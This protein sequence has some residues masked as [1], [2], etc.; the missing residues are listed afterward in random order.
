[1]YIA[2][3]KKKQGNKTYKS[4]L[5]RESYRDN[6][7]VKHRTIA[8]ISKL[9]AEH[10]S[11]LKASFKGEKSNINISDLGIGRSYEYGGSFALREVAKDIGL[12]KAIF[13]QRT[14]WRENILAMII[15]RILYQGSK[16]NLVNTYMD[17]ALWEIAGHKFGVRPNIKNDCYKPMDELLS[18]KD[19]IERK[20]AKRHLNNGSI[21]LYDITNTWLEGEYSDSDIVKYGRGKGGKRG[22]KQISIGLL[23]NSNGCPV[24]IEIFKGNTSD[25]TTVL[26]QIRKI[27][28]KYGI[29]EAVFVGD[30]GMLTQKRIN[31]IDS[32]YFKTVTALSHAELKTMIEKEDIQMDLFDEMNISE[33]I[34]SENKEFRY[35]LCKNEKEKTKERNTREALIKKMEVLLTKKAAV[36]QKRDKNKTCA[37]MGRLFE[38]VK[39]EKFFLWDVDDDGKLTWSRKEEKIQEEKLLD[40]CYVIKTN[41]S[42]V[43]NKENVV[44]AYQGLQKVEQAFKNMKTVLLE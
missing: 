44:G 36:K 21:L 29:K 12:D 25:Q 38:K 26:G 28:K 18:R 32:N 8:N 31:E 1:M 33:I 15:G 23:T 11:Q 3:L 10:I 20:F 6:G 27:S 30:R 35:M 22:Y 4:I 37:S 41:A 19:I 9:P 43:M 2:E 17:T 13:S 40:G 24:G 7:K 34:D 5:I 16:L 39:I 14:K 42:Q